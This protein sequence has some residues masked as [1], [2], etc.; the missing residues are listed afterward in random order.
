MSD[1]REPLHA[2]ILLRSDDMAPRLARGALRDLLSD[3]LG[4]PQMVDDIVLAADELIANVVEHV[5]AEEAT[6]VVDVSDEV[7]RV[8][9]VDPLAVHLD[10]LDPAPGSDGADTPPRVGLRIVDELVDRWGVWPVVQGKAVWFEVDLVGRSGRGDEV[11]GVEAVGS[12]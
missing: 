8:E 1:I 10:P 3:R 11:G 9:V 12:G 7:V 5:P 6:V 2:V 4:D